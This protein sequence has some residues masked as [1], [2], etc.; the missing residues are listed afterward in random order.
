MYKDVKFPRDEG[1]RLS[2]VTPPTGRSD[3]GTASSD[4]FVLFC[5]VPA[6]DRGRV[7]RS[8][9]RRTIPTAAAV[10]A[11]ER[12]GREDQEPAAPPRRLGDAR[13]R[14][15]AARHGYSSNIENCASPVFD[16]G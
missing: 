1:G 16:F 5:P 14:P 12:F 2:G 13:Q 6:L 15:G 3:R 7:P 9:S 10:C 4:Q 8:E 11:G